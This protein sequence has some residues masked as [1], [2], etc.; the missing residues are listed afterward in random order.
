[1]P[2][3]IRLLSLLLV[4]A[5]ATAFGGSRPAAAAPGATVEGRDAQTFAAV[6][7]GPS[8]IRSYT[9]CVWTVNTSGGTAPYTYSWSVTNGSGSGDSEWYGEFYGTGTLYLTLTDANNQTVSIRKNVYATSGGAS[10]AW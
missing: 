9:Q 8:N 4:A 3:I 6:I 1:M 5:A 10:C 2:K 7:L